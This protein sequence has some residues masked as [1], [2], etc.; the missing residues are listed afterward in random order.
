LAL[1]PRPFRGLP[2]LEY[3]VLSPKLA[4]RFVDGS[5][6][7]ELPALASEICADDRIHFLGWREDIDQ[8]LR[9]SRGVVMS[10]AAEDLPSARIEA[11]LTVLPVIVPDVGDLP[12]LIED[13]GSGCVTSGSRR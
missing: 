11:M 7:D 10:S 6:V 5:G 13:G 3:V 1:T 2:G 9:R 8:A 12:G 4:A